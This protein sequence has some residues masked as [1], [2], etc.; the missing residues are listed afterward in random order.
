VAALYGG[1]SAADSGSPA[2]V[3]RTLLSR[4]TLV[5]A[6]V[7]VAAIGVGATLAWRRGAF[8]GF[9]GAG[10]NSVAVLP[11]TNLSGDPAQDY[12]SAGLAEEVRA[13]LARNAKLQVMAQA[14]SAKFAGSKE[15][16]ESIAGQ[17]GVAYLL[18]GSVRRSGDVVRVAADLID[19]ET[20]FGRWSQSFD[21]QMTDIFAV[22]SEIATTVAEALVARVASDA[23]AMTAMSDPASAGGTESIPAFDAYLQGRALYDLSADEAS[24][25]AALA[26]FDAA[27]AA[28]PDYAAAWAARARSLTAIANQYAA[29]DAR[30]E[31]YDAAIAAAGRAIAIAP[32]LA[33]AHSTLGYTLFQGRLDARAARDPYERSMR[34]GAGEATVLARYAQYSA[35]CGRAAEA[36]AAIR[37]A[38]PLDPLNPL[39]FR[40]ASSI[41]F[42]D[43]EYEASI[44]PAR[45]ALEMNPRLSRAH[46]AIG[47]ALAMLGRLEDARVEYRAEPASDFSLA[48]LA[49]VEHRLGRA[50]EAE[51][52]W[53]ALVADGGDRAL[54]QQAQV[55]AQRGDADGALQ[56]L[57]DARRL[58]DS[59]LI[60]ARNDPFLDPVR[61]APRFQRLLQGIGFD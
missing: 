23:P 61:N 26:R 59:G 31:M 58:G 28:D 51:Q 4:R 53:R 17:L 24:E 14:S 60:Y 1:T 19:G 22:Q 18:T 57:E 33:D 16:A 11:F 48:G 42:A 2:A 45:R 52:A 15:D 54:Y 7:G 40:A 35:R 49:I 46:A 36:R 29:A 8:R 47:D 50:A 34:T 21:R 3:P 12:F 25:R 10:G 41:E 20:G 56:R 55:L 44:A 9:R 43:R 38:I 32:D 6:G 27:I 39:I 13:T 5:L 30:P 37:R